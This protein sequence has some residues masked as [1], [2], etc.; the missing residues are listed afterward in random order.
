MSVHDNY[1][2]DN[3]VYDQFATTKT[4]R[5][6]LRDYRKYKNFTRIGEKH[7]VAASTVSNALKHVRSKAIRAGYAPEADMTNPVPS[8]FY[9]K[10]VSTLRDA[11]GNVVMQWQKTAIDQKQVEEAIREAIA[12]MSEEIPRVKPIKAPKGSNTDLCNV[13]TLTDCHIGMMAWHKEGGKDWDLSIAE[14]TIVGCF[15][16]M[17]ASSQ[18][19]SEC[20]IAQLGDF[21]HYD[22]LLA[23]TPTSGHILDS[24]G[25]F[26]KM[27]QIAIRVLRNVVDMALAK[28]DK[29]IL[30]L[31]E[32]NHD[33]ASSVWLRCMFKALYEK[34]PRITVIDSE[35]PYY[36]HRFGKTAMFW[37]HSHMKRLHQ[38]PLTMAAE[39]PAIW[40]E[41]EYRFCHTG[42]KH[43]TEEK[44]HSGVIVIQ[45]PTLAARDAYSSR[46]GWHSLN[47][48]MSI[49]YHREYGE[50]A[51]HYVCPEML[52]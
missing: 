47:R 21:L 28:H 11:E 15:S 14:K 32:G 39:F 33:M 23:V 16:E 51:R 38:L 48:A 1:D 8:P 49:T 42:D 22:G 35:S 10:G 50:V 30:L 40:G 41:T 12:A 13:Y 9:V 45:H 25:R 29:V 26:S 46:H 19:A 34:E 2:Y 6:Y 7:G 24:D 31:A 27:V 3:E 4:Q 43:H 18:N 20:V 36:A 17:I 44:E 5:A 37:H 52:Q